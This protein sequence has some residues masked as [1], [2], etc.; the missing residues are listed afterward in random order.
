MSY[1]KSQ[2]SCGPGPHSHGQSKCIYISYTSLGACDEVFRLGPYGHPPAT[3]RG[4][5]GPLDPTNVG[6]AAVTVRSQCRLL[7]VPSTSPLLQGP[8]V[9]PSPHSRRRRKDPSRHPPRPHSRCWT[10]TRH[11]GTERQVPEVDGE[12]RRPLLSL[13]GPVGLGRLALGSASPSPPP[14]RKDRS[15]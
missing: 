8:L 12:R 10:P 2:M 5:W 15:S 1:H 6:Q 7:W 9:G 4:E 11:R 3:T 13:T 14:G